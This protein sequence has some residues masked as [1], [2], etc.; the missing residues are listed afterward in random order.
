MP[1]TGTPFRESH[2]LCGPDLTLWFRH[3]PDPWTRVSNATLFAW[4]PHFW[5]LGER[6]HKV[7]SL[8]FYA[9][10]VSSYLGAV[11]LHSRCAR[12]SS[13]SPHYQCGPSVAWPEKN[14]LT[15][16]ENNFEV[17]NHLRNFLSTWEKS[18]V[19]DVFNFLICFLFP[20]TLRDDDH[21]AQ[22]A[23]RMMLWWKQFLDKKQSDGKMQTNGNGHKSSDDHGFSYRSK[24]SRSGHL[25]PSSQSLKSL[26]VEM[27]S[28][29]PVLFFNGKIR[30]WKIHQL[31]K[32]DPIICTAQE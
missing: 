27:F 3:P 1:E 14:G 5:T 20:E 16:G 13:T 10:D 15:D 18:D 25:S 7:L 30:K 9:A 19:L 24:K 11:D 21:K 12:L 32:P 26:T 28:F 29:N 2:C 17:P 23:P 4:A 6:C 8:C 31:G 22:N